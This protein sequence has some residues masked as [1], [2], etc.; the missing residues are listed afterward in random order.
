MDI[1]GIL[2]RPSAQSV[3]EAIQ[4]AANATGASFEYMLTA[5]QAESGLNPQAASSTSSARGLYQFIDQTWLATL[6]RSGPSLGYSRYADAIVQ[7]APG[8]YDVPDPGM[9]REIM[10]LRDDPA[11]NAAMAGALTRDNA[12]KLASRLGRAPSD[13]ELYVAHVLGASGAAKLTNLASTNPNAPADTAFPGA[14]DANRSIFYDRLGRA[15]SVA[16]VRDTLIARYESAHSPA[17][18]DLVGAVTNVLAALNPA[19]APVGP[20]V[21]PPD[22][23][24]TVGTANGTATDAAKAS[25]PAVQDQRPL[26]QALFSDRGSAPPQFV[27]D[28]W[29]RGDTQHTPAQTAPAQAAPAAQPSSAR[30][31]FQAPA[32]GASGLFGR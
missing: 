28:L 25:T 7:T 8:R 9:R 27:P 15:R 20:A 12:A 1:N 22:A 23:I 18:F 19:A 13:G 6:K 29:G 2:N 16:E 4:D 11:A 24:D 26:F 30:E 17:P 32:N 31:L 21:A 5:A 10:A 3:S 14:A